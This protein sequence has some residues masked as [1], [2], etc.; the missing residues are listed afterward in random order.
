MIKGFLKQNIIALKQN[1]VA[2]WI[3][4]HFLEMPKN[5]LLSSKVFMEFCIDY[6][7]IKVLFKTLFEPWKMD[8]KNY[9]ERLEVEDYINVWFDNFISKTIGTILRTSLILW[10]LLSIAISLTIILII[11]IS[12]LLM[13]VLLVWLIYYGLKIYV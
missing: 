7:S 8:L 11:F 5:I 13:P 6:F 9:Q 4:W 10:G 2:Q 12:W 1:I 3:S